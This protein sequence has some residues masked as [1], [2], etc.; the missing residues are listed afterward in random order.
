MQLGNF[1]GIELDEWPAR[2]AETAM[3][4]INRQCDQRLIDEFGQAPK[5]LPITEAARIVVESALRIDWADVLAPSRDVIVAGNPPYGGISVRSGE[6]TAELS[7]V[8]GDGYH[9][10]LDYVTGWHAKALEYFSLNNGRWAFVTTNSITQGEAVAPLFSAIWRA[11]WHITFAYRSFRWTSSAPGQAAVHCVIIGFSRAPSRRR[12]FEYHTPASAPIERDD[13][14]NINPYLV[15]GPDL[16]V[17][18]RV[19]PLNPLLPEVRYGN[20]PTDGGHFILD[21]VEADAAR[22]DPVAARF[23]R[24]YIGAKELVEDTARWCL[25]LVDATQDEI[26]ASPLLMTHV[27]RVQ[28]FRMAS[29]ASSTRASAATP[30]LFRQIAQPTTRYLCIPIHVS[31]SR[32]YFTARLFDADVIA[33]NANFVSD[34]PDG[35]AFALISS[36][37]FMTWQRTVGGRLKS[38]LRFNKLLVW[39][40]FPVPRLGRRERTEII[41]AGQGVMQARDERSERSLADH[42][43]MPL[44]P[45]L[46]A[47]H[48]RLDE[49]VDQ[50][51]GATGRIETQAD[52]Q[53][54]LF[55]RYLELIGAAPNE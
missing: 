27:A 26:A 53:A 40:T 4:L 35:L 30:Q 9:G 23:V 38:D 31:E 54:L 5:R 39:N 12:L 1:C 18:P 28:E 11:G 22:H 44:E 24:P 43:R 48:H 45:A 46:Q 20:K 6:Q 41:E 29:R 19:Y 7:A 49:T 25:W 10:T 17:Q 2:L 33:S 55:E 37:M 16:V 36:S 21:T 15:D 47:A 8:W 13:V 3:F 50:V 14:G 34:D 32:P 51:F 52:R 42:Y